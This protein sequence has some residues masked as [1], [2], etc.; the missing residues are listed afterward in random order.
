MDPGSAPD[1][2]TGCMSVKQILKV[3]REQKDQKPQEIALEYGMDVKD[4]HSLMLYYS[5]FAVVATKVK[6]GV[7]MKFHPLHK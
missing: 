2:M 3:L 5:N 6:P 4:I 7:Q 1:V